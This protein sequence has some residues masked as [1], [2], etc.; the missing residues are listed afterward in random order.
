[1]QSGADYD[2]SR[3]KEAGSMRELAN[4]STQPEF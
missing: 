4:H 3:L 2:L 1:M